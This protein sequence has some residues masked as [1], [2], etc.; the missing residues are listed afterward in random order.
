MRG[1]E[2][3]ER[4]GGLEVRGGGLVWVGGRCLGGCVGGW[5]CVC[6]G[7]WWVG[8]VKLLDWMLFV[9]EK[10]GKKVGGVERVEGRELVVR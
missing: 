5:V 2:G 8:R 1:G 10:E 7:S 3:R 9:S 6:V 4:E